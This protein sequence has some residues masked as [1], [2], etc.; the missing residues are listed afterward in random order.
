MIV[1]EEGLKGCKADKKKLAGMRNKIDD[2]RKTVKSELLVPITKFEDNCKVLMGLIEDAEKPLNA[3][4]EVFNEKIRES[5]RATAEEDIKEAILQNELSEKYA[6]QLTVLDKYTML[7]AKPK[8]SKTDICE[9]AFILLQDQEREI[10]AIRVEKERVA[11]AL[12]LETERIAELAKIEA[13]RQIELAAAEE[14]RKAEHKAAEVIRIA[15]NLEIAKSTIE[16]ANTQIKQQ[17][18]LED[19]TALVNSG[20]TTMTVIQE[21]NR[22]KHRIILQETPA[23]KTVTPPLNEPKEEIKEQ[24]IELPFT[25]LE[26]VEEAPK[27]VKRYFVNMRAEGTMEEIVALSKFLKDNNYKY[28]TIDKGRI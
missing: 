12:R 27:E 22:K 18:L 17:I 25:D 2:Y 7:S 20:A 11:E 1:T 14:K 4:I 23:I 21:I 10:E 15:E 3:G 6:S 26:P 19:F 13:Q 5:K 24:P 28:E 8:T 9:R 16:Q